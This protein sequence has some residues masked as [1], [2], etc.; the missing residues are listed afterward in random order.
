MRH[1]PWLTEQA[2]RNP[3]R[4]ALE[5]GGATLTYGELHERATA[6]AEGLAG[7]GVQ[8]GDRVALARPAGVDFV[9]AFHAC[10]LA[11]AA[12]VPMDPRLTQDDHDARMR[13][14]ASVAAGGDDV[15][16]VVH[17]SGT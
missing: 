9:V 6:A 13:S 16:M 10:L 14:A 2:R 8:P 1:E 7:R 5:C 17:T 12:V 3:D 11:R 15:L 4:V